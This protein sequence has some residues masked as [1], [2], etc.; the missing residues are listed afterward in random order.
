[1]SDLQRLGL[2]E[3]VVRFRALIFQDVKRSYFNRVLASTTTTPD[4]HGGSGTVHLKLNRW[5]STNVPGRENS[6]FMQGKGGLTARVGLLYTRL[7]YG[8]TVQ[9]FLR[10]GLLYRTFFVQDFCTGLL[11]RT[12]VQDFCAGLLCRA[13]VQDLT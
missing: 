6:I 7:L 12:S 3:R 9:D 2:G 10:T 5:L 1:M 13:S 11:Y 4:R 8:T